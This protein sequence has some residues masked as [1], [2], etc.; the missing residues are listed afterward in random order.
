MLFPEFFNPASSFCLEEVFFGEAR[1][2]SIVDTARMCALEV[3]APVHLV[4]SCDPDSTDL[5]KL[6]A[7]APFSGSGRGDESSAVGLLARTRR[8]VHYGLP[9]T[10]GD[11]EHSPF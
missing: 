10:Q 3:P 2:V 8:L 9:E 4:H 1:A 7:A 6:S 5:H 11:K